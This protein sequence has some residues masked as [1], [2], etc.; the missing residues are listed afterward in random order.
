MTAAQFDYIIVGAGSAGCVLANRL[1]ENPKHSVLLIEA[2]SEASSPWLHIPIGYFKTMHNPR[3]DWCYKTA[4]EWGTGERN[5][6]WPRGKVLG[7]S[8]AINGLLYIRG[9]AEDYDHWAALGNPGWAFEDVLPLFKRSENNQRGSDYYH[10]DQGELAVS[11]IRIHRPICDAFIK[12]AEQVGIART[13]D[14]NGEHQAGAGYFQLNI[15]EQGLRCS[16]ATAFLKPVKSRK[17]LTI[18][19]RAMVEKIEIENGVA[20]LV[21]FTHRGKPQAVHIGREVISCAGAIASP[22]LLM[23]SGVGDASSLQGFDIKVVANLPGVGQNLQDHLQIRSIYQLNQAMSLN[24]ELRKPLAKLAMTWEFLRKRTGPLT[25]AAS[26]V[27]I[28]TDSKQQGGRPDIQFH[29]QPLSADKPADGTHDFSGVTS[30]VCQL[31]PSSRGHLKL[32]SSD[33]KTP[34]AIHPNY[35]ASELDQQVVIDAIRLSRQIAAAPAMAAFV[36]AEYEPGLNVGSDQELLDF[37]R[38]RSA[39]I[40]HPAG[41]CKMGQ[42]NDKQAVVDSSLKVHGV[43]KLRVADCSIMPQL[44]SGNTHAAA[45]MIGE[46]AAEMILRS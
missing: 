17:N 29:F 25:M 36:K 8:S 7:G 19:T 12:A 14:F 3:W 4:A 46:K 40:Y 37:A 18:L 9:Q 42:E 30:S 21:Q 35:L 43:R 16:S 6:E 23:V 33:I 41:T 1:S 45:V 11:D 28:F 38:H 22:H 20:K 34:V 5:L 31:R 15:S 32:A 13:N 27:A 44:I 10:G 2:G 26:Q 24:D 39:T